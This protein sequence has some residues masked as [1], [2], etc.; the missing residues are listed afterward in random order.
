MEKE[1]DIKRE[2]HIERV[3]DTGAHTHAHTHQ[4]QREI[5]RVG[6]RKREIVQWGKRKNREMVEMGKS[7]RQLGYWSET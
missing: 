5:Q 4:T 2:T 3:R 7:S 1:K 6:E